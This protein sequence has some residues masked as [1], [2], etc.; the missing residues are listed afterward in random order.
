MLAFIV[1]GLIAI[2]RRRCC[3][4]QR[5]PIAA[6]VRVIAAR[7]IDL[8][9]VIEREVAKRI[10]GREER[11]QFR[12]G[13]GR[14]VVLDQRSRMQVRE[15][16]LRVFVRMRLRDVIEQVV[17]LGPASARFELAKLLAPFVRRTQFRGRRLRTR[18]RR[19]GAENAMPRRALAH[20]DDG[21]D[22][23][24]ENDDGNADEWNGY[25]FLHESSE[26]SVPEKIAC[27]ARLRI[28]FLAIG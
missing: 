3:E 5:L 1:D 11:R 19:R 23:R 8:R 22:G 28:S 25:A 12:G 13:I 17:E 9:L 18:L 21:D 16:P 2:Q 7:V 26:A 6:G 4:D 20:G 24:E 14:L 15:R 10:S 27:G